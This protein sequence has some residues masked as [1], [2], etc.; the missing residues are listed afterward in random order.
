M[1]VSRWVAIGQAIR[2]LLADTYHQPVDQVEKDA[3][4]IYHLACTDVVE[5]QSMEALIH[6][7]NT[8]HSRAGAQV[9]FSSISYGMDTSP[10]GRLAT[11]EV[12]KAIWAGLG[13]GETPIFPISVFQLKA[14]VNYNPEDTKNYDLFHLG[15]QDQCKASVPELVNIDAP[16]NL[17]YYKPGDYNSTVATMGCRTRVMANVNGPEESGGRETSPLRR[18][19]CRS[20]RWKPREILTR[21]GRFLISISR[22]LMIT[23][24]SGCM[25]LSRSM[26][27]TIR[28]SWDRVSGWAVISLSRVTVSRMCLNM[29]PIRSVSAAWQSALR[30]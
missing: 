16:Y 7:F 27:I 13:N 8:L 21:S 6:N 15:L 1:L 12:L 25:L 29:H 30:H 5:H 2:A 17:K 14:G 19:T 26:S 3:K 23:C 10:E 20:W 18:S 4:A 22:C 11:R 24:W 9:P 28:S